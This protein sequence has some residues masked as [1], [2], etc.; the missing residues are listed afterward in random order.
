MQFRPKMIK[1]DSGQ[2]RS[3]LETEGLNMLSRRLKGDQNARP[4]RIM[5]FV[6]GHFL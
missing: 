6:D 2:G 5:H 4:D 1:L 3:E